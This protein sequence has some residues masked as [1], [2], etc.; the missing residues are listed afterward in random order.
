MKISR[1]MVWRES[2]T[3]STFQ[4]FEALSLTKFEPVHLI[5]EPILH[6][7]VQ[8]NVPLH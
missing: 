3:L 2:Q 7:H 5:A 6:V 8:L 4:A 1:H